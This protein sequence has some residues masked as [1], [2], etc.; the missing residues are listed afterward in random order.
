M[1]R[2]L[3]PATPPLS[4]A[5]HHPFTVVVII[6]SFTHTVRAER[7]EREGVG[8]V[9]SGGSW[10]KTSSDPGVREVNAYTQPRRS[11]DCGH[12]RRAASNGEREF[13]RGEGVN[14]Q[15]KK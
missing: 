1:C 2:N 11:V 7:G 8:Q 9:M 13:C 10:A 15:N 5:P 4:L 14:M 3:V 6:G 12:C